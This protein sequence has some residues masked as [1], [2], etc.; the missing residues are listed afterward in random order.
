MSVAGREG[1]GPLHV[2][3]CSQP[4]VESVSRGFWELKIAAQLSLEP[5]KWTNAN[6]EGACCHWTG[7]VVARRVQTR[8]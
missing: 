6:F 7:K 4:P 8:L 1:G 2:R 5:F 3:I